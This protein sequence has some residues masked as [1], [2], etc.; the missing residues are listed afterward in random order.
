[1]VDA[2]G[3]D[4]GVDDGVWVTWESVSD[5]GWTLFFRPVFIAVVVVVSV[6]MVVVELLSEVDGECMQYAVWSRSYSSS[7][8]SSS[9]LVIN[10][11]AIVVEIVSVSVLV[12]VGLVEVVALAVSSVVPR[13]MVAMVPMDV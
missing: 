3:P 6:A 11:S 12:V 10:P 7:S 8:S 4:C 5:V 9:A 13:V 2:A 1:M